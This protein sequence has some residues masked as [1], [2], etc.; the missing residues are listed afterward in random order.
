MFQHLNWIPIKEL[1]GCAG[2]CSTYKA[3]GKDGKVKPVLGEIN[4]LKDHLWVENVSHELTHA[5]FGYIRRKGLSLDKNGT[6]VCMP[7]DC[8]EEKFCY[9]LGFMM[10]QITR[11]LNRL[12]LW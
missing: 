12:K 9:A 1:R 3:Y 2:T 5:A 6:E 10:K 4:L 11:K 8:D 7:V